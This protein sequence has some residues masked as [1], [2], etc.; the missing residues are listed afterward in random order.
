[1][2]PTCNLHNS[3]SSC[4]ARLQSAHQFFGVVK[5]AAEGQELKV[6]AIMLAECGTCHR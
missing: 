2:H 3:H 6:L 5:P 4:T 1:M